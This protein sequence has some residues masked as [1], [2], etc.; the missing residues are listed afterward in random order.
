MNIRTTLEKQQKASKKQMKE[1][2]KN[3]ENQRKIDENNIKQILMKRI[4][5]RASVEYNGMELVLPI[6]ILN[7]D[8][9]NYDKLSEIINDISVHPNN[10]P[11]IIFNDFNVDFKNYEKDIRL[12]LIHI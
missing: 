11:N 10:Y 6:L 8:I 4:S 9:D 7:K 3:V 2:A 12:S 1:D 5:T